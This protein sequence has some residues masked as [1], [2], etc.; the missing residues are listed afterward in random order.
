MPLALPLKLVLAGCPK[1]VIPSIGSNE[2]FSFRSIMAYFYCVCLFVA[3]LAGIYSFY[4]D[5][6]NHRL[7]VN[8]RILDSHQKVEVRHGEVLTAF[9][10]IV[11]PVDR[12]NSPVTTSDIREVRMSLIALSS[13]VSAVDAVNDKMVIATDDY[14]DSISKLIEALAKHEGDPGFGHNSLLNDIAHAP[15]A[16]AISDFNV[17]VSLFKEITNLEAC[18]QLPRDKKVRQHG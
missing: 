7:W 9:N 13:A 2:R 1:M 8:S 12:E 15:L 3:V 16:V 5:Y 4:G 17:S 10:S 14:K 11:S 18:F 6:T